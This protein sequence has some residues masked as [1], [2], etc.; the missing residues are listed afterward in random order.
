[1]LVEFIEVKHGRRG[2]GLGIIK[3]FVTDP[4]TTDFAILF[5]TTKVPFRLHGHMVDME[6]IVKLFTKHI[7]NL[8]PALRTFNMYVALNGTVP[9]AHRPD[10]QVMHAFNPRDRFNGA[11]H[12]KVIH[13][14]RHTIEQN[15]R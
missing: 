12:A 2:R 4:L 15:A 10:V 3:V 11:T 9:W 13:A 6:F 1:M 8:G 7:Q 5:V 14:F